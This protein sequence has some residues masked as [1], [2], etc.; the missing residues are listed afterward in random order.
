M[1]VTTS[2]YLSLSSEYSLFHE[3]TTSGSELSGRG[4][5]NGS[6]TRE[7]MLIASPTIIASPIRKDG[8]TVLY[9]TYYIFLEM[10]ISLTRSQVL[11]S[12]P[13]E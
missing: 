5:C 9:E 10:D 8:S 1:L 2:A 13:S 3:P 6:L 7:G 11:L 12:L 4:D